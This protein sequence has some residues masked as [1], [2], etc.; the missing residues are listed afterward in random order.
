MVIV[1]GHVLVEPG[2]RERYLES[3]VAVVEAAR[4]APGCLDM[5]ISADLVDPG[6]VNIYERWERQADVDAFRQ[7]GPEFDQWSAIQSSSVS[8]YEVGEQRPLG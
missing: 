3:C 7:S 8:E 6:R 1:A 4:Q 2:A 5:S